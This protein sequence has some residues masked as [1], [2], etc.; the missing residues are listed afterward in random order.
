MHRRRAGVRA[1]EKLMSKEKNSNDSRNAKGA[2]AIRQRHKNNE[3]SEPHGQKGM[4]SRLGR[5]GVPFI[6]CPVCHEGDMCPQRTS[7]MKDWFARL[8]RLQ[9]YRCSQCGVRLYLRQ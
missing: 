6:T 3:T 2:R 1:A 4:A 7:G 8:V 9:R 5:A